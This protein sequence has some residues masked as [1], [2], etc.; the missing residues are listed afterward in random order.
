[1]ANLPFQQWFFFFE[2]F[3]CVNII[4]VKLSISLMLI[5]IASGRTIIVYSQYAI[6]GM[7]TAMNLIAAFYIIF[8]CTPV[9]AA[10]DTSL[11]ENGGHCNPPEDLASIYYATT[12]VNIFTDWF[13]ALLYV[14]SSPSS[15]KSF[16]TSDR[17]IPLLW[18][19]QL[20]HNEK[21]S[22][23]ALLGLGILYVYTEPPLPLLRSP[24]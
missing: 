21:V 18:H 23:A 20:S 8:Q 15:S 11:I 2:V 16:L 22:V 3:Y 17:P 14:I 5:R 10:W 9:A 19:V 24:G 13:T 7:F 4:P 1:M 12:A 6:M